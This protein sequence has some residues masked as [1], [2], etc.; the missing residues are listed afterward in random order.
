MANRYE[1]I[2]KTDAQYWVPGYPVLLAVHALVRDNTNEAVYAQCKFTNLSQTIEAVYISI[3]C[4]SVDGNPVESI[5][6][7][8]YLD[9]K[10]QP[11]AYFGDDK[12][13]PLPNKTTRSYS[14]VLKKVVFSDGK[15]WQASAKNAFAPF[16][17][18]SQPLSDLGHLETQY[19]QVVPA[20][21][22]VNLPDKH[23]DYW[24]CGCGQLNLNKNSACI[25]CGNDLTQQLA[26]ADTATLERQFKE[27]QRLENER[28]ETQRIADERAQ[29]EREQRQKKFKKIAKITTPILILAV[30]AFF[31]LTK[32]IIPEQ[33]Y[34]AAL[35]LM[36]NEQYDQ[37]FAAFKEL[38]AYKDS[39]EQ[40]NV[41]LQQHPN[42]WPVTAIPEI[43]LGEVN[44][45]F[46]GY[47][48]RVLDVAENKA[49]LITDDIIEN[50]AYNSELTNITWEKC[51]LRQYL[52]GDFYNK[53]SDAEKSA[54]IETT[55]VNNNNARYGTVGGDTTQDKVFL[56]SIDEVNQY[57]KSNAERS[58]EAWWW[59]RSP[60]YYSNSAAYVNID[61]YVNGFGD[62]VIDN[63][64]SV[65][66]VLYIN[67]SP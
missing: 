2:T 38:G 29:A 44:V 57:F 15:V 31:A 43:L 33:K 64:G 51:T 61:G 14:V 52:N 62:N 40:V 65:R 48:W 30:V 21:V 11:G 32:F 53:F 7:Y 25:I 6:E 5:D 8:V 1:F 20:K 39:T 23:R 18:A 16:R 47:T 19:R 46:G 49:L 45:T 67:L 27:Y 42:L 3:N 10:A 22:Q 66:P 28:A 59:L 36:N 9:L 4:V 50:R 24:L 12:L 41:L 56:L 34:V 37:A 17:L 58:I 35:D 26:A 13:I 55:L 60:G 54:I 63:Y